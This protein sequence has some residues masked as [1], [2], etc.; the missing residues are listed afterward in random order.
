MDLHGPTAVGD[1][2]RT[3]FAHLLVFAMDRR[4]TGVIYVDE[5]S[6][7]SHAVAFER[8]AIVHASSGH[9]FARLGKL[10][11]EAGLVDPDPLAEAL[12]APAPLGRALV[13]AGLLAPELLADTLDD[14]LRRR[15]RRLFMLPPATTYRYFEEHE[16]IAPPRPSRVDPLSLL[17]QGLQAHAECSPMFETTLGR[18]SDAHLRLHPD[19]PV[20]Q[21]G[22]CRNDRLLV[23]FLAGQ[24]SSSAELAELGIIGE[25]PLRRLLYALIITRMVEIDGSAPGLLP[26]TTEDIPPSAPPSSPR[27]AAPLGRVKLVRTAVRQGAALE[28]RPGAGEPL[29]YAKRGKLADLIDEVPPSSLRWDD[30]RTEVDAAVGQV[31][32]HVK[33]SS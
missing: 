22:L 23:S 2:A 16:P 27:L 19:A 10:L 4:L 28:D 7:V 24:P 17:W 1:F 31:E 6:D 25:A 11:L 13:A 18:L 20:R 30:P 21:L 14:Q 32:A 26:V 9:R 33:E 3:P 12:R 29:G 5:S 8:G 15:V